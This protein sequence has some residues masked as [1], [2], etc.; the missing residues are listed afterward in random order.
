[1]ECQSLFSGEKKKI[2]LSSVNLPRTVVPIKN[3]YPLTIFF[4]CKGM[5][6]KHIYKTFLKMLKC[7]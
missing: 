7:S 6:E 4:L 3:S 1:M 2:N 5:L